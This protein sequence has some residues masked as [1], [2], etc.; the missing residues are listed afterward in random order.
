V[1]SLLPYAVTQI[2]EIEGGDNMRTGYLQAVHD[3]FLDP[4]HMQRKVGYVDTH[5]SWH[6]SSIN[7]RQ[8]SE[9][10]V[11]SQKVDTGI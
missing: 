1:E 9:A 3:G 10:P 11:Y 7:P 8:T 2:Q 4:K 5:N 6:W